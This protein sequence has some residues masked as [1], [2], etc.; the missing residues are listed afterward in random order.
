MVDV[1]LFACLFKRGYRVA[2][3][4]PNNWFL[5]AVETKGATPSCASSVA[6]RANL[7]LSME[8]LRS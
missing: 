5:S 8:K 3:K 4:W 7:P 2:Q 1:A 6:C